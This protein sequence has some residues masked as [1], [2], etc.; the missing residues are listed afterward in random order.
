VKRAAARDLYR[1]V[2]GCPIQERLLPVETHHLVDDLWIVLRRWRRRVVS[3]EIGLNLAA[4]SKEQI[5]DLL[6]IAPVEHVLKMLEE[7]IWLSHNTKV[8]R[9]L[10]HQQLGMH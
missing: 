2:R 8:H 9:Q 4:T 3:T 6:Q 5:W 7:S 1:H 10:L